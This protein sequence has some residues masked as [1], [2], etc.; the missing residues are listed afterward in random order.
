MVFLYSAQ[1]RLVN[2]YRFSMSME[3]SA[4]PFVSQD[5][6]EIATGSDSQSGVSSGMIQ[7]MCLLPT[8]FMLHNLNPMSGPAKEYANHNIRF[9]QLFHLTVNLGL[10]HV[11]CAT[12]KMASRGSIV[13]PVR[14]ETVV[15]P[16]AKGTQTSKIM[17]SARVIEDQFIVPDGMEESDDEIDV[18]N[19]AITGLPGHNSS[20]RRQIRNSLSMSL[21]ARPLFKAAYL[22]GESG[23]FGESLSLDVPQ[24]MLDY[25]QNIHTHIHDMK[26]RGPEGLI[27][28]YDYSRNPFHNTNFLNTVP[29]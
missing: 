15:A 21:D 28:L 11:L 23:L 25:V 24:N 19:V 20:N 22:H 9:Y 16:T 7:T 12:K 17:S 18:L 5:S 26:E 3:G 8:S 27:T 29:I 14:Y 13:E 2:T 6:F 4:T 1:S 10:F